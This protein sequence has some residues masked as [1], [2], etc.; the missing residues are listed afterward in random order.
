MVTSQLD[1]SELSL[2]VRRLHLLADCTTF[3]DNPTLPSSPSQISSSVDVDNLRS[4][5]DAIN[6]APPDITD[7]NVADL[8][9]LAAEFGSTRLLEQIKVHGHKFPVRR[10]TTWHGEDVHHLFANRRGTISTSRD[11]NIMIFPCP[12]LELVAMGVPKLVRRP[13]S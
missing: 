3:F 8:S 9:S 4:F 5:V 11:Q 7:T 10:S 2:P 6:G 13:G 12:L 1:H